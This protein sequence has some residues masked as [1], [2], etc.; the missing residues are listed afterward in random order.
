MDFQCRLADVVN[1]TVAVGNDDKALRKMMRLL[2][3]KDESLFEANDI[4]A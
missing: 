1:A 4:T 3:D 2:I